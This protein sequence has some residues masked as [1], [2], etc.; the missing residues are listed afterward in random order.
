[1]D[2]EVLL[3][4]GGTRPVGWRL[5]VFSV[6]S[7]QGEKGDFCTDREGQPVGISTFTAL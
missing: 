4:R 1:M 5:Q 7:L 3:G 6:K 2:M